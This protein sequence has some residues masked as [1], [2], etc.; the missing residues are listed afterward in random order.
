[1]DLKKIILTCMFDGVVRNVEVH[2]ISGVKCL[3]KVDIE[4]KNQY[5]LNAEG[6]DFFE[7]FKKIRELDKNIV[8][9][10]K[11]AKV[12]VLPSRMTRQ[13]S[14]GLSAYETSL[15]IPARKENLVNI[16]DYANEGLASDP[17]EQDEYEVKW[18]SSLSN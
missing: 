10:C 3:M 17:L 6:D 5:Q 9:Y 8:Y 11:G 15:G 16:F 18:F 1:M 4:C 7:C 14:K 12:N 2:L 13:M